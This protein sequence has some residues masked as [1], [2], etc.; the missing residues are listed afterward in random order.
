[1]SPVD[2]QIPESGEE[3]HLPEGS[4]QPVG[5]AA[6]ATMAL[7][8]VTTSWILTIVGGIGLIWVIARWIR[9]ARQELGELPAHH[10]GH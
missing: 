7:V 4:L 10:D 6:F 9:D 3:I 8:G 2:P 5:V 1:M